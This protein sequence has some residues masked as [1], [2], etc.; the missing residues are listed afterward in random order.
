M[1]L[2]VADSMIAGAAAELGQPPHVAF[3]NPGGVRADLATT[4]PTTYNSLYSVLPF[5]NDLVVMDMTG[6]EI[7]TLIQ[8]QF[9]GADTTILQISDGSSFSWRMG[10][11]GPELV[12]GSIR[13]AGATLDRARTYRV[14]TNSFLATGRDGFTAFGGDR[15]RTF[16][17][18]DIAALEAYVAAHSPIRAPSAPRIRRQ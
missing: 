16:V 8:Q 6:A 13:I 5:G 4:G 10:A 18:S 2:V 3:Q 7:E 1:G 15:V 14:V 12:S 9:R 17:G 11:N